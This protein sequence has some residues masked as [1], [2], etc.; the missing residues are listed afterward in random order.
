MY[1]VTTEDRDPLYVVN[2]LEGAEKYIANWLQMPK[3]HLIKS[4]Y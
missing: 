2:T 3:A 1:I 4:P